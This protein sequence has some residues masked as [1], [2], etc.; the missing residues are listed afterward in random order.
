MTKRNP[1]TD[2]AA[3]LR[4]L[5]ASADAAA[6]IIKEAKDAARSE[7]HRRDLLAACRLWDGHGIWTDE[8]CRTEGLEPHTTSGLWD[9]LCDLA[10]E[11][12]WTAE[13]WTALGL[14]VPDFSAVYENVAER[15]EAEVS[16]LA[17]LI[18]A[19]DHGDQRLNLKLLSAACNTLDAIEDHQHGCWICH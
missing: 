14:D 5:K 10:I 4:D 18:C 16:R 9:I 6:R 1:T 8:D 12:Y 3:D 11:N 17:A 2:Q 19:P 7:N 13:N 15:A